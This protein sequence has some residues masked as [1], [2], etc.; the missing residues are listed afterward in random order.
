MVNGM[1]IIIV[2][3]GGIGKAL[4]THLIN[5]GHEVVIVEEDEDKA[6]SAAENIDAIV[7]NGDGSSAEILKDAGVERADAVAVL[8]NDD[9][10]NLTICQ[11]LKKF[12]IPKIVARVNDP[13]KKDLYL[14]LEITAAI[15]VVSAAV[16]HFK[17]AITKEKGRSMVSIAGG[18]AEVI[19]V[20]LSNKKLNGLRVKDLGFPAGA[21]VGAIYRNGEVIIGNPDTILKDEDMLTI[22]TKTDVIQ[23]VMTIL[24]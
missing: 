21:T 9:N 8:T 6:K 12:N 17:N 22:I 2:G 23:D 3:C 11:M 13:D 10:T 24:R 18:Q 5:E 16:S 1:Y 7:I 4:A 20:K 14:G 19:E 15:S